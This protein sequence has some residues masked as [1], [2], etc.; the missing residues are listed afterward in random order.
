MQSFRLVDPSLPGR[1]RI[2]VYFL[3]DPTGDR[4]VSTAD[5]PPLSLDLFADTLLSCLPKGVSKEIARA[6]ASFLPGTMTLAEAKEVRLELMKERG[7][8]SSCIDEKFFQRTFSL[9]EH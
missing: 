6:I 7:V 9:C 8:A 5:V 4:I 1:R 2:L 3:I